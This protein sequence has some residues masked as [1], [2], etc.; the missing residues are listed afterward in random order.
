MINFISFVYQMGDPMHSYSAE[1]SG[2][3]NS[4]LSRAALFA[5]IGPWF[6]VTSDFI[7]ESSATAVGWR[8][9]L[10]AAESFVMLVVAWILFVGSYKRYVRRVV[11]WI[12]TA[13]AVVLLMYTVALSAFRDHLDAAPLL[14]SKAVVRLATIHFAVINLVSLRPVYAW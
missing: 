11:F 13:V 3:T 8:I 9:G 12:I 5:A 6:L 10:L 14:D 1:D 4:L 7:L 2:L